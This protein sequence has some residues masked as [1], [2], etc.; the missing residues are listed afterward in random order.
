MTQFGRNFLPG[1]TDVHPEVLAAQAQPMFPHRGARMHDLLAGAQPALQECFG[2]SQPVFIATCSGTGL[3]EAGVRSG[4]RH[5]LLVAVGGYFGEYLARIGEACGKEV[6]RVHVHPGQAIT[7]EQLDQFLDGPEVDAVAVVHSETST[8]ALADIPALARVVRAR[9]DVLFLVDG[10][11]SVGAMPVEMD[12]WDVDYYCTGSQKAFGLPPGLAFGAASQRFQV[13]AQT[14]CD[15]GYYLSVRKMIAIARE[16]L[17][18]WTPA[19]SLLLALECQLQR[20]AEGGGWPARW[21]RHRRMRDLMDRWV[22]GRREVR[23]M[24]SSPPTTRSPSISSLVLPDRFQPARLI[25]DLERDGWFVGGPLDPRHGPVIRIGHM[26][27]L[28]P[29]HLAALLNHLTEVI[30]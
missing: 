8:G 10:V 28:E 22:E 24:V 16:N 12:R 25:A 13:R 26:G 7:P 23:L 4:V 14:L 2:T 15:A 1:P 27:D 5:R 19:V 6:L 17:P 18:W 11:T 30:A 9:P 21:E 3:L 29:G 20:V